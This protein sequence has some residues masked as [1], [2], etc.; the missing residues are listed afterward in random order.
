[1]EIYSMA[2]EDDPAV[3]VEAGPAVAP[4]LFFQRVS[5]DKLDEA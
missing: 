1:M 5:G 4:R 2:P 3:L